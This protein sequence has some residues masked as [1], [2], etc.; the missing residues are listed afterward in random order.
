MSDLVSELLGEDVPECIHDYSETGTRED[1]GDFIITTVCCAE[2]Q[3]VLFTRTLNKTT[4]ESKTDYEDWLYKLLYTRA[5]RLKLLR[6][7]LGKLGYPT[8]SCWS[9]S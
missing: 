1:K 4:L 2:C 8:P 9:D 3:A 6:E 7:Y 5:G